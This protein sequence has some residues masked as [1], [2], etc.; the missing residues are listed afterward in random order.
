M[1][2]TPI[3]PLL[4][5]EQATQTK[6][7]I[8]IVLNALTQGFGGLL[9]PPASFRPSS[10]GGESAPTRRSRSGALTSS[11]ELP[12]LMADIIRNEG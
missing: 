2:R 7:E 12:R 5:I 10:E 8:D 1:V 6:Q 3:K 9:T 11:K 4:R